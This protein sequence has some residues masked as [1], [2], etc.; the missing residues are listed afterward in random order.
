MENGVIHAPFYTLETLI[1]SL[2][3]I[4]DVIFPKIFVKNTRHTTSMAPFFA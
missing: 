1:K 2:A 3:H 4:C